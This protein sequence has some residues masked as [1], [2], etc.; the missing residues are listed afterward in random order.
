MIKNGS[1]ADVQLANLDS[2]YVGVS[3]F[4]EFSAFGICTGTVQEIWRHEDC[5]FLARVTYAEA[6]DAEDMP[7]QELEVL[8]QAA[9]AGRGGIFKQRSASIE[10]HGQGGW[11]CVV[12][13]QSE[14]WIGG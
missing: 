5:R 11:I 13:G 10:I 9:R 3:F 2:R 12:S 6:G 14:S 8:V 1:R 7:I 4:K